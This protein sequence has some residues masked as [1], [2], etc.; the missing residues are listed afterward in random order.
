MGEHQLRRFPTEV[1]DLLTKCEKGRYDA[2]Q[3]LHS[4]GL[5]LTT[6]RRTYF[7]ECWRRSL[8]LID[9]M[10]RKEFP[11]VRSSDKGEF[12]TLA[13]YKLWNIISK[14][15]V[16]NTDQFHRYLRTCIARVIITEITK[17]IRQREIP[18]EADPPR[19][20]RL[21]SHRDVETLLFLADLP[22]LVRSRVEAKVRF[23]GN[24]RTA[25][26]Y[27]ADRF[28]AGKTPVME[29]LRDDYKIQHAAFLCEYV[30]IL[31]REALYAYK[32]ITSIYS[33]STGDVEEW[34]TAEEG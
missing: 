6:G 31:I 34:A 1:T 17:L 11:S 2:P 3:A 30:L 16:P 10:L 27:I 14:R 32:D 12:V 26:L 19:I 9:T 4:Y 23:D 15:H 18:P 13:S 29:V 22:D 25:C 24:E 8:P 20:A 7:H 33:V 28:L 21:K 5:W